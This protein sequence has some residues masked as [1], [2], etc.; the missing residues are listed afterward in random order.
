M[1]F[2]YTYYD[3]FLAIFPNQWHSLISIL[4]LAFFVILLYTLVK[5]SILWLALLIL[6]VPASIPVL[7]NVWDSILEIIK[8]LAQKF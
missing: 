2:F 7:H 5:R 8:F 6:I 1:N 4:V 3:K